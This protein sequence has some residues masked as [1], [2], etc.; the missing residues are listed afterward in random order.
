MSSEEKM[1]MCFMN[2]FCGVKQKIE[3]NNE[4][5]ASIRQTISRN[6]FILHCVCVC[7]CLMEK[8]WFINE[9]DNKLMHFQ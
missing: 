1:Y 3:N 2:K 4:K 9:C 7:V 8:N 6:D 5:I